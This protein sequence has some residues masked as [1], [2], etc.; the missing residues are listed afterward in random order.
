MATLLLL[1]PNTSVEVSERVAALARAQAPAG[2]QVR[3]AT[4]AF[5]ARYIA[6]ECAAAIAA[7]AALQA[8]A[9]DVARHGLPD[10]VLL[11]CFGDPGLFALRALS[12]VPVLGLAEASMQRAAARGPFVVVTGGPAWT[13]M[14]GR[15]ALTLG[16]PAPL[17]GVQAVQATGGELAADPQAARVLL[18]Q[19][20]NDALQAWPEARS[21]L[22]GGAG[23]GGMAAAVAPSV[24]VPVLDNVHDAL[25][26]AFDLLDG[27]LRASRAP[28]SALRRV[29]EPGPWTGLAA[30]LVAMLAPTDPPALAPPRPVPP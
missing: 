10:A 14:L 21:V 20:A 2:V 22:L 27:P 24:P 16:L 13:P 5:G 1:N 15:L 17:L 11:A 29:P 30:E 25:A 7:H 9:D 18:A 19:A 26:T 4:A 6:G 28:R 12:P 3:A 8:F 23:L